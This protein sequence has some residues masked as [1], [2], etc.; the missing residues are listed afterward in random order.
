MLTS[1]HMLL[2]RLD[3]LLILAQAAI[4]TIAAVLVV[5]ALA[6]LARTALWQATALASPIIAAAIGTYLALGI[7]S[8]IT[9]L[10]AASVCAMLFCNGAAMLVALPKDDA[11]PPAGAVAGLVFPIGLVLLLSGFASHSSLPGLVGLAIVGVLALD[12]TRDHPGFPSIV[13]FTGIGLGTRLL[14]FSIALLSAGVLAFATAALLRSVNT[15]LPLVRSDAFV[16]LLVSPAATLPL[17]VHSLRSAAKAQLHSAIHLTS[18]VT[19]LLLGVALPL[20]ILVNYAISARHD[21]LSRPAGI[22]PISWRLD[23]PLLIMA[24]FAMLGM[25]LRFLRPDR[26]VAMLFLLIYLL[27]LLTGTLLR[28]G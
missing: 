18:S 26:W 17:L 6:R 15:G 25:R 3:I 23:S 7:S 20:F 27:Y 10:I 24:G 22:P 14:S 16:L 11:A 5:A 1:L 2:T 9:L 12:I 4:A 21:D 8:A 28:L 13:P 19:C